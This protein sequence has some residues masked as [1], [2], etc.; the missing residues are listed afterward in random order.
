LE[1]DGVSLPVFDD[2]RQ[3]EPVGVAVDCFPDD[4]VGVNR[5][6]VALGVDSFDNPGRQRCRL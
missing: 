2:L 3:F 5:L 6:P 4:A 1:Q